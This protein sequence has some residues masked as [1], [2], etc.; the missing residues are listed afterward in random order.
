MS[1]MSTRFYIWS[2]FV[3]AHLGAGLWGWV[4][5]G[6]FFATVVSGSIYFPLLPLEK[7]GLPVLRQGTSIFAPPT[8]LGWTVVAIVWVIVYWCMATFLARLIARR[9]RVA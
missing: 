1:R 2:L 7:L 4:V 3:V 8:I 9:S 5:G 6:P